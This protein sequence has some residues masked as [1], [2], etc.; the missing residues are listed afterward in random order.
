MD[1][2]EPDGRQEGKASMRFIGRKRELAFL[3]DC[4]GRDS[5]QLVVVYGRRRVGKTEVLRRFCE[6]KPSVFFS[7]SQE[8]DA[9]TLRS[10]SRRL[11]V[12]DPV[13]SRLVSSYSTWEAAFES[14]ATLD[15]SGRKLVVIDEFP[16]ACQ[17]NRALPSILQNAWDATLSR[18]DV[19][20]VLC[21]S[22]VSFMEG[23]LLGQ[24]NP[25]YGRATGIWKME[26]LGFEE[27]AGFFPDYSPQ[28]RLEAYAILGG[29]PQYLNQFDPAAS[30]GEN[31]RERILSRGSAL[32]SE[33]DFLIRQ[34][35]REPAVYNTLLGAIAAGETKLNGI[36]QKALVDNRVASSY[37]VR[38][39]GMGLVEREFPVETHEKERAKAQRGL[40]RVSDNFLRFWY[41][42]VL[43]SLSELDA[44]DVDGVW[45]HVVEPRLNDILSEGFE[46]EC[47]QWVRRRNIAGDLPF[48]YV[49]MGRWWQGP[50]EIDIMAIAGSS[51]MLG[52]CKFWRKP[53]GPAVLAELSEKG[54]R[55]FP[56]AE[57]W[58]VLFAKEGFEEA[59]ARRAEPDG[60]L[61][62]VDAAAIAE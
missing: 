1:T 58:S 55:L 11:L 59:L 62:L 19:M 38:L 16:N 61:L 50:D 25:L 34:E 12:H 44:G 14:I 3:E 53:I 32:H 46:D 26:P 41:A 35:L 17:A 9:I 21:G 5:A 10:F 24:R 60:R 43:P 45:N 22:S 15:I 27:A 40:Y 8:T 42:A 2:W 6:G 23:E 36:S 57:R 18:A 49:S 39:L 30:V 51:L 48:R 47:R 31:V 54:T 4:Y 28:E 33:A 37:L 13:A 56:T 7:C 20:L 29:V 52:E